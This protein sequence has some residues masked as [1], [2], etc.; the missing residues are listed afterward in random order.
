[1]F[2]ARGE[3]EQVTIRPVKRS[4]KRQMQPIKTQGE[5]HNEAPHHLRLDVLEGH[6]DP[7]RGR[8]EAHAANLG[9]GLCRV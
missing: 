1:M 2:V 4:L 7:D 5:R 9:S 8:A 3:R 6:L